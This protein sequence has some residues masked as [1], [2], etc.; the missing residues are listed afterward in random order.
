MLHALP[1]L[2]EGFSCSGHWKTILSTNAVLAFVLSCAAYTVVFSLLW[3]VSYL[4]FPRHQLQIRQDIWCLT[5]LVPLFLAAP[6]GILSCKVFAE[7]LHL[8]LNVSFPEHW[9]QWP[10]CQVR[11]VEPPQSML[12]VGCGA[13]LSQE[14][15]RQRL[16]Y[17]LSAL[18]L[19]PSVFFLAGLLLTALGRGIRAIARGCGNSHFGEKSRGVSRAG[20]AYDPFVPDIPDAEPQQEADCRV[21]CYAIVFHLCC[22]GLSLWAVAT[23]HL[24]MR[25]GL[26][27]ELWLFWAVIMLSI[28]LMQGLYFAAFLPT[29]AR[30]PGFGLPVLTPIL[31]I[32]G[33]P[34]DTFK[35]WLFVGLA[36]SQ[37]TW[38][39]LY[40]C[41][42][43]KVFILVA[44]ML[45]VLSALR[46]EE[47][48][49]LLCSP[50]FFF[51]SFFYGYCYEN[52]P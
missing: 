46:L 43:C 6:F 18:M 50:F 7:K 16:Q 49:S 42:T 28:S 21:T 1:D 48:T 20:Y 2:L 39:I 17:Y 26:C 33:E 36:I 25:Y 8:S 45:L 23:A 14:A 40:T 9:Q 13:N 38:P 31:P 15:Q 19:L 29:H 37:R 32:L 4:S 24:D 30:V 22:A 47:S 11:W 44:A 5:R 10:Q 3:F 51:F 52:C 41:L 12:P 35:D 34:L 27:W